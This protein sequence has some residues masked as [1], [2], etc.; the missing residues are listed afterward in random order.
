MFQRLLGLKS[1]YP[2]DG[3]V[4][5]LIDMGK[6]LDCDEIGDQGKYLK[7]WTFHCTI[8]SDIVQREPQMI[9]IF[10]LFAFPALIEW[11]KCL[12]K[13]ACSEECLG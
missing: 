4:S 5:F 10:P 8:L 2:K 11:E 9:W 1:F 6:P 7:G 3:E 12:S 13:M